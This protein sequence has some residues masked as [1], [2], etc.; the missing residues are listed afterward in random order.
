[1]GFGIGFVFLIVG[2]G[3]L[4]TEN[5][6]VP[7]AG[8]H[9]AGRNA[10]WKLGE[11]WTVSPVLNIA[12]GAFMAMLLTVHSVLP[13]GTGTSAIRT[14]EAIHSNSW[15]PLF[16]S[17]VVG[18]ALITAMTWF[19]EGSRSMGVRITV[20]WV[21]GSILALGGFNHAIVVT[22]EQIYG[23]RYGAHIPWT[24]VLENFFVAAAGNMLGGIGLVTL[25]RFT[26]ARSGSKTSSG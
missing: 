10:W 7:L 11:L 15:L 9:G 1:L 6:L 26:Q 23:I 25:N 24:F 14:A 20:A 4:F 19:V 13:F 5:F 3:E 21:A 22:I 17:A 12:A 8:L 16:V 18:G 2:R